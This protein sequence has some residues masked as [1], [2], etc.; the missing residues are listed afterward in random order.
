MTISFGEG[1]D[2]EEGGVGVVEIQEITSKDRK[3]DKTTSNLVQN[4]YFSTTFLSPVTKKK[5]FLI[6]KIHM[7]KYS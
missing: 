2:C 5:S 3:L 4:E 6:L 7:Q 1:E